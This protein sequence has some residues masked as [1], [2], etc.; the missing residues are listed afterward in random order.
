MHPYLSILLLSGAALLISPPSPPPSVW[1]CPSHIYPPCCP[2]LP[3]LSPYPHVVRCYTF[4]ISQRP[5]LP[6]NAPSYLSTPLLS[7]AVPLISLYS[8]CQLLRPLISL[9][10]CCQLLALLSLYPPAASCCPSYLSKL[11]LSGAA[12]LI[13][14]LYVCPFYLSPSLLLGAATLGFHE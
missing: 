3:S 12:S 7:V 4:L 9:P 13:S 1:C 5:L 14:A 8:C 2:V 11:L 6:D 10:P